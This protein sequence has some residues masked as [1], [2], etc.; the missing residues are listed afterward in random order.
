MSPPTSVIGH[1][2]QKDQLLNDIESGSLAHAYLFA[3]KKHL[4]K[5]TTAKWFMKEILTHGKGEE[6]MEQINTLLS[7]NTHPDVLIL[8]RL[9]IDG[10][11]TDWNIIAKSSTVPQ[12]HRAKSKVKTDT[13]TIDDIRALQERLYETPQGNRTICII[14]SVE[15]LHLTAA[16]ALLKILEE[17]PEHV[18]FCMTTSSISSL[19]A[20]VVSRMRVL[21]FSPVS[22]K[23]LQPLVEDIPKED[24]AMVLGIAQGAPGIVIRCMQEDDRLLIERQARI[25]AHHF[26]DR[27]STLERVKRMKEALEGDE[28]S[29]LFF[30]H[31]FLRLQSKLRSEKKEDAKKASETIHKFLSLLH[32]LKSNVNRDLV[33]THAALSSS[34]KTT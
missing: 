23:E 2:T 16:N 13:I 4:G 22:Q 32:T 7:K 28:Q 18:I 8:N 27:A 5:F 1:S 19:P 14:R 11:C 21:N 31:L 25:D 34:P 29:K 33:A 10:S 24:R 17:P 6:E 12:E 3:G 30:R 9:W 26:I 20:T 15:R